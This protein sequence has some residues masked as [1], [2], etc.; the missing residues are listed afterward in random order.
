MRFEAA[1]GSW[2]RLCRVGLCIRYGVHR[3][4]FRFM[5]MGPRALPQPTPKPNDNRN[6]TP[7][8]N[9][10]P[11]PNPDRTPK[12]DEKRGNY[13]C[14]WL[15]WRNVVSLDLRWN[16]ILQKQDSYLRFPLNVVQGSL[17]TPSRLKHWQQYSAGDGLCPLGCRG[18]GSLFHILC[19]CQKAIQEEP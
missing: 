9:P 5:V 19:Q 10:D 17:P 13:F 11:N 15:T 7:N 16:R 3:D 14:G 12:R 2:G 8:T 6:A 18:T 4:S 1:L